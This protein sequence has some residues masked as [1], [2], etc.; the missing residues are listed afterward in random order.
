MIFA[1]KTK[2]PNLIRSEEKNDIKDKFLD[3]WARFKEGKRQSANQN[4]ERERETKT[5]I[6]HIDFPLFRFEATKL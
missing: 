4:S 5:H 1:V 2:N 6:T 3:S